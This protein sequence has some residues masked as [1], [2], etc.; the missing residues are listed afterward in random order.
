VDAAVTGLMPK[1]RRGDPK[2]AVALVKLLERR[3][4]LLG[5][6]PRPK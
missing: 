3:A 6:P 1:V 4:R 2:A 5:L